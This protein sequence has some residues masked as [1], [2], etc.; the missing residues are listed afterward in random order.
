M[1][2]KLIYYVIRNDEGEIIKN[3]F[4]S[5]FV[6]LCLKNIHPN[7]KK[8]LTIEQTLKSFNLFLFNQQIDKD[9]MFEEIM[10]QIDAN[11]E[12]IGDAFKKDKAHMTLLSE[13]I[14]VGR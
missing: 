14:K 6:E 11:K 10:E 7:P 5:F 8:R 4:V 1:Y 12:V 3:K 2:I 9:V 13:K